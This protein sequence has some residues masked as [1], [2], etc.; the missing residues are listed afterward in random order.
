MSKTVASIL[1][2]SLLFTLFF[3]PGCGTQKPVAILQELDPPLIWPA[4]PD[5]ARIQ[6]LYSISRPEDIGYAPSLYEKIV[7]AFAGRDKENQ[8]VRPFETF[9]SQDETLYVTDPGLR[10]VHSFNLKTGSYE[11]ITKYLKKNFLSPI[12]VVVDG[13][14]QI[15]I[16]DSILGRVFV[17]TAQGKP[18]MEI[19]GSGDLKR[20]T[21][22]AIH[23]TLQR[24]YVTDTTE[25]AVKVYDLAGSYLFT[26]GKRGTGKAEFNFPTSIAF[27]RD[28]LLHVNDSLN[29]RV[30]ILDSEGQ[31]VSSF[32]E[33][34][35][36][37]G[38]FSH[39]K[40]I[41]LDSEANIYVTDAIFDSV[42]IFNSS[43]KLLLYFGE[44]GQGP[45]QLWLP[46]SIY[47]DASDRV[48]VSDS[49]NQRVQVFKFLGGKGV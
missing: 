21:G 28:G 41:A 1:S 6:Y 45:G 11:R 47:I 46:T 39:A 18:V 13:L 32:G 9:L 14:G 19:G 4:P 2:L 16:S 12:G 38:E 20:P 33:H 34:G 25:H 17:F 37:M 8:I 23:P 5:K 43:G 10:L 3:L 35:D 24:L 22:L 27:S 49:Y 29:Y 36:G 40:G 31:Y 30:Q 44:A 26:I 42:Q 7:A 48:F 15:Y